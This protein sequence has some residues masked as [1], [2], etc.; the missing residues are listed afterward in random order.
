MRVGDCSTLDI[1][2]LMSS[3]RD[4]TP[5]S[6]YVGVPTHLQYCPKVSAKKKT[7][8]SVIVLHLHGA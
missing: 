5:S 7:C 2:S 4:H 8:V 6:A 3:G 1:V